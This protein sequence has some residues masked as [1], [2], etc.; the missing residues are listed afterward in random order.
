MSE[1]RRKEWKYEVRSEEERCRE[2]ETRIGTGIAA[3][4]E[5]FIGT[6]GDHVRGHKFGKVLIR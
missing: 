3:I 4:F 2:S 6:G 5:N 1:K